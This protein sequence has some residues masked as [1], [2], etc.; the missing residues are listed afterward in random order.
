MLLTK[1]KKTNLIFNDA[2]H[3]CYQSNK[4]F[5]NDRKNRKRFHIYITS[6]DEIKEGDWCYDPI[7]KKTFL[8]Q[9]IIGIP[10]K[11]FKIIATSD[12]LLIK[13]DG[14]TDHISNVSQSF[15]KEFVKSGGK[16]DWEIDCSY[17]CCNKLISCNCKDKKFYYK[18]DSNY[19]VI[20]SAVENICTQTGKP[21]GFP[22]IDEKVCT[23]EEKMYSREEV[24]TCEHPFKRLHWVG[25]KLYCNKCN[26]TITKPVEEKMYTFLEIREASIYFAYTTY[27]WTTQEIDDWIK[28]N[29]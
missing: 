7:I 8:L 1:A 16:E 23:V 26:T 21:C 2:Y 20:L 6:D 29:L 4:S 28:E 27:P 9:S 25:T 19:C 14:Y 11:V 18:L 15:L 17:S 22:C 24:K 13:D 10:N 3:L 12:I 5:K